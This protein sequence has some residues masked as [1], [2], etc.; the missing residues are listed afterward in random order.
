MV[1]YKIWTLTLVSNSS[2]LRSRFLELW[3]ASIVALVNS[4]SCGVLYW[5]WY[6]FTSPNQFYTIVVITHFS[7]LFYGIGPFPQYCHV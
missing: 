7:F 3:S 6:H 5:S 4:M 2:M 1:S